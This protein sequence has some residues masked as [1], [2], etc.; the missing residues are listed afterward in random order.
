MSK[1]PQALL[2]DIKVLNQTLRTH[3]HRLNQLLAVLPIGVCVMDHHGRCSYLNPMGQ[4]LLG[5]DG[6]ADLPIEQIAATYQI[7]CA[8]TQQ[9]YPTEQ[10]PFVRALRGETVYVEDM[11]I[12]QGGRIIALEMQAAPMFDDQG[13]I[14]CAFQTFQD[15]SER[16]RTETALRQTEARNQAIFA[17]IPDLMLR[18][19]RDGACLDYISPKDASAS[20]FLPIE[21]NIAEV[22]PSNLVQRQLQAI[23]QALTTQELQI[24]EHQVC[25]HGKVAY[26]EVRITA[27]GDDEVLVI[28]RDISDRKQTEADLRQS[29]QRYADLA[30]TAPVGIFRADVHGNCLY[31]NER[32][33]EMIGLTEAAAMGTGW[34]TTLHPEDRDRVIDTWIQAAQ[35]G[36]PFACE[37]RFLAQG[38]TVWVYGQAIAEKEGDGTVTG[39]IGTL[40]DLTERK[41][42]EAALR[43]SEVYLR[44][45]VNNAPL[46]L[47]AVDQDG[48]FTL[49]EG[50]GLARLGLKAGEIVGQSLAQLYADFPEVVTALHHTLTTGAPFQVIA[51]LNHCI[52]ESRGNAFCDDQG[53]LL[54]I[55]GVSIDI[56]E[57]RQVEHLLADYNRKLEQQVLERTLALEQ[58]ISERKKVE[59][60]LR[61]VNLE[62]KRLATLDG[63]TQVANR[64][65]FDE[66]LTQEWRRLT[67]E[68]QPLSLI[69]CDVDYFKRYN[70]QYGH[71]GGD[72]C[73]RQ[74]AAVLTQAAQRSADLVARYGGEEFAVILPNTGLEGAMT[75]AQTIQAALDNLQLPNAQS[76][77]SPYVTLSLG[78][79]S[80]LPTQDQLPEAL[81]AAAD[82]ALYA[83]KHQ[84]RNRAIASSPNSA[85]N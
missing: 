48:V 13:N 64:R 47:W 58:E 24:Y 75:V 53:N 81:V 85:S 29:Q 22:L 60:A 76:L 37:Y 61:E 69:L 50:R 52:L 72:D 57:H 78:I 34:M 70:D 63:L 23:E 49:S 18:L 16:K 55:I 46:I 77:V 44:A 17:A 41:K 71:Q 68:Q 67:R 73:L 12:H 5:S 74:V 1:Q 4:L 9:L 25:K 84:G 19:R 11:E 54:G 79:A 15:I 2:T 7:Y 28:V 65:C 62:L 8:G 3:G 38:K 82:K 6:N 30:T 33:F 31:G 42:A 10:L 21:H 27:L 35:S 80:M 36:L 45:V 20:Q 66:T 83:A 51:E 26:E 32:S 39:Y 43:Q 59:A 14:T 56:T 40:T